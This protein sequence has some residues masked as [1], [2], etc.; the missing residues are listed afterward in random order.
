MTGARRQQVE[1]IVTSLLPLG[2][3]ERAAGLDLA[4]GANDPEL[5]REVELLLAQESRAD[6]F[7]ETPALEAAAR[8]LARDQSDVLA[9][10]SVGPYRIDKLLGAGGMGEVYYGWDTRLRRPVA[11]KFLSKEYLHDAAALERF[12]REARAASA[13]SHPN[14]C[15][16]HDV[17]DLEGRP[18]IAMEY[19]EGQ[20]LRAC[21]S[22]GALPQRMALEYTT[23]VVQGLAAAHQKGV[24]HRD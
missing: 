15:V 2:T 21:I 17:G 5:R 9:G 8:A 23:Q 18:F 11:L 19:L 22:G 7:L 6:R 24:V 10:R 16:V 13:L 4:C 12:Q 3:S 20:T 1:E 14:I